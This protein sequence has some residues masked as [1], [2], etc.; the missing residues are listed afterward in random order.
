MNRTISLSAAALLC[1]G[2]LGPAGAYA[3][4][5]PSSSHKLVEVTGCLQPGPTGKEYLIHTA[6]GTTW[7][8][9]ETDM[10]MN[11]Y[12]GRTVTIAGDRFA[13][14]ISERKNG[15]ASQ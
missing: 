12:V 8:V 6:D 13:P 5:A 11:N 14:T 15:G 7:G 10:L 4:T 2:T 3:A 9:N 1:L